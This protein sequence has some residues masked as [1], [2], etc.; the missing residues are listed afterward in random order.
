M[1]TLTDSARD[2]MKKVVSDGKSKYVYLS[3]KGGGC[4]GFQYDWSL[5]EMRGFGPTIDDILCID[6]MAEMFV[7]GC[8][9]DY[10]NELGGSFLKVINPNATASCGCGES[11]AV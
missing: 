6:D 8:T 4:S 10:V 2:Y 9:I 3:V 7:A 5:S 11:F 1:V